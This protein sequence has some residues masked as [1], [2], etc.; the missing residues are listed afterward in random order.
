M[1]DIYV[2]NAPFIQKWFYVTGAFGEQR[3]SHIHTGL[4][5]AP[6]GYAGDLYAIDKMKV[7]STNYDAS[8]YG[9]Y[10]I[11]RNDDTNVMYLYAHMFDLSDVKPVGY[12]Y[13][14]GEYIGKAGKSGGSSGVHL[15]LAMQYG[16]SW[17]YSNNL[18]DY[19]D[20]TTYLSGINNVATYSNRYYCNSIIPPTPTPTNKK[21]KFPWFIYE[22]NNMD[23]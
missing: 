3:T 15:H 10:V 17:N 5:L 12:V 20:P 16:S 8:G 22:N 13:Q 1:A 6:S 9:Y 2:N 21:K 4:D 19:I 7:V 23:I 14:I 11:F 18:S